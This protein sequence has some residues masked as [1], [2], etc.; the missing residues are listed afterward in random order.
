LRGCA[1]PAGG[2]VR[3]GY[4]TGV[5]NRNGCLGEAGAGTRRCRRRISPMARLLS[6]QS[7]GRIPSLALL[8]G[9]CGLIGVMWASLGIGNARSQVLPAVELVAGPREVSAVGDANC[10]SCHQF[11]PSQTHP[12][13]VRPSMAV[14]AALPLVGGQMACVTCHEVSPGHGASAAGVALRGG[15]VA[16]GLCLSCHAGEASSKSRVHAAQTERAHLVPEM[17]GHG[18]TRRAG[19]D[20]ESL[21][22]M[23]CHDGATASDAASHRVS[24]GMGEA[25]SEHPVGVLLKATERTRGGD[26]KIAARVDHRIRLFD[27]AIGCGSCH[28]VYSK[29]RGQLVMSNQGSRLCLSCHTQ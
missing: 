27:G 8:W 10:V 12:V 29:E 7:N 5:E 22:C 3:A 2:R 18:R 28:S 16:G 15:G 4:D 25:G 21:N 24:S 6:N 17:P 11:E 13:G 20:S 1:I 26:F 19:L 23:A 14:P 9:A